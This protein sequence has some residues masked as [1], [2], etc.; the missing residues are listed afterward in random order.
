MR[1]SGVDPAEAFAAYGVPAGIEDTDGGWLPVETLD[2]AI[3][4]AIACTGDAGFGLRVLDQAGAIW[5]ADL[6]AVIASAP[7]LVAALS[8]LVTFSRLVLT[9]PELAI[10]TH[11]PTARVVCRPLATTSI[12]RRFRTEL[13]LG[14]VAMM[15]RAVAPAPRP[16]VARFAYPAPVYRDRYAAAFGDAI[17]FG[18][19]DCHVELDAALLQM[20][21][22]GSNPAVYAASRVAAEQELA[23]TPDDI[24]D[25]TLRL[26]RTRL[27]D[28]PGIAEAAEV[29]G[30]SERS[31]RRSLAARDTSYAATIDAC[32]RDRAEQDLMAVPALPI[33]QVARNAGFDSVSAFHRAFRRW[34]ASTPAG[35]RAA[36]RE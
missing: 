17:E 4:A 29:L 14:A 7:T 19:S 36:R 8:D 3:R 22:P 31:L 1:R 26:V 9:H 2:R 21:W 28:V 25:R 35:W 13:A 30:T 27:P 5:F 15:V 33:K 18:A 10:E 34:N 6:G 11:G 32:R 20:A 16:P 12:G 23:R 24:A